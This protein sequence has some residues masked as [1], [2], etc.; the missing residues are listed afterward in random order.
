MAG[1]CLLDQI[2]FPLHGAEISTSSKRWCG[3]VVKSRES[4]LGLSGTDYGV[5]SG[6]VVDL[7]RR[8]LH[9][10]EGEREE[11]DKMPIIAPRPSVPLS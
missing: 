11:A 3:G 2:W 8:A 7:L 6:E 5:S 1:V 10:G 4:G 9:R